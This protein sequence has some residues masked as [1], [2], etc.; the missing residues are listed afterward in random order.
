MEVK[1]SKKNNIIALKKKSKCP[2]C[3]KVSKE[4][5]LPFCS[6]KCASLDLMK[7]LT[8]EHGLQIKSD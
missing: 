8:D 6:K 2:T 3:K 7:W 1:K 4:P 5:F